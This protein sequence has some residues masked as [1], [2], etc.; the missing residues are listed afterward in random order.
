[1]IGGD[2]DAFGLQALDFGFRLRHLALHAVAL[3]HQPLQDG[4]GHR[5]LLAKR[6]QSLRRG[7]RQRRSLGRLARRFSDSRLRLSISLMGRL[8]RLVR[9]APTGVEHRALQRPN[10]GGDALIFLGLARLA[11]QSAETGVQF[12]HDIVETSEIGVGGAQA[13]VRLVPTAVQARDAGGLLQDATAVGGLGGDQL[14]NL[15]LPHQGWGVGAGGGVGEQQLHV[16]RPGLDAV[17]AIGG[18][19]TPVDAAGHF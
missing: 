9:L 1:M 15:P 4:G 19:L 18:A 7:C 8:Q 11:L 6:L 16:P 17:D 5:L 14:G 12:A 13:Q 2:A 3:D 10:L